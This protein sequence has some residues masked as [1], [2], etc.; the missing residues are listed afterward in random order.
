MPVGIGPIRESNATLF[1]KL[2]DDARAKL[3]P[4]REEKRLYSEFLALPG[5]GL[6]RLAPEADCMRIVDISKPNEECLNYYLPGRAISYSFRRADYSHEAY[7]DI[8]RS[9][10]SFTL[11]GTLVLGLIASLGDIPIE[12]VTAADEYVVDLR[13]VVPPSG[14][15]EAAAQARA[16]ADGIRIGD[17]DYAATSPIK[18]NETYLFRSIA[19][20]ARFLNMGK[21][22]KAKS[23]LDEDVRRDIVIVFRVVRKGADDSLL[24][25]WRE[26]DRRPA[27]VLTVDLATK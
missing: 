5:T 16:I 17:L 19:Y 18:E 23:S 3:G 10:G 13:G 1:A 20:G 25:L 26:L 7:A 6:V 15:N 27:P 21:S 14:F 2:R 11:P 9:K 22:D 12:S 4:S 24:L 8:Q